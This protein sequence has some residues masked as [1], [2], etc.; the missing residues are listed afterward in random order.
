[1]SV[2]VLGAS[3]QLASHLRELLP[4][5][6]YWGRQ[7]LDLGQPAHVR[8]AIEAHRPSAIVNA[9]AYTAVDKAESERDA[10]WSLNAEAP[11]VLA[12]VAAKLDVPLVHV[13][14]DYV[15]NGTKEGEYQVG[16]PCD[17]VNAYG[18][19]KLVGEIA[20]RTLCP[21]SWILRTSWLFSEYGS[22]FVKT[23]LRLAGEREE[24]RVVADQ[25]GRPTYAGDL[26][27]LVARLARA[28]DADA[29]VSYGT[30]HAVGGAI[31]SWHGFAEAIV[32]AAVSHGA[33]TRAPRV[34]PIATSEYPTAARRPQ[35]SI[36]RP[37]DEIS[38]IL[39]IE[40]DWVQ[41]LQRTILG[42]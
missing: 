8:A 33:L 26:A 20:V 27:R 6:A 23:I 22:N 29:R 3:G 16:D 28:S 2:L 10:A 42:A 1:M 36:L 5:A 25:H 41:G 31:V 7:T 39:H 4:G 24:L 18:A 15:F 40:F 14:T 34:I 9:A 21:R 11:A 12:R 35:N 17:P 19:T 37:S 13:S 32:A 30:Y 38:S